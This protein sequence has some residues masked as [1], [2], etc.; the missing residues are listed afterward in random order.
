MACLICLLNSAMREP[1]ENVELSK[2]A[3]VLILRSNNNWHY[4][5]KLQQS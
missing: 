5:G 1:G 3:Y 2:V 4:K